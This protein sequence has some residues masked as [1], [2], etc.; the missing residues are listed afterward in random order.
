MT[1]PLFYNENFAID[2]KHIYK[3]GIRYVKDMLNNEGNFRDLNEIKA[4]T[5]S[6]INFLNYY[7]IVM[8][9]IILQLTVIFFI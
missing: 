1:M 3:C 9:V 4:I 6:G 2:S 8:N 7:S 5:K